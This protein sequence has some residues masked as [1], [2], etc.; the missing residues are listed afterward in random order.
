[1]CES[2]CC[3]SAAGIT[4]PSRSNEM[5]TKTTI[6]QALNL[7]R[8]DKRIQSRLEFCSQRKSHSGNRKR[9]HKSWGPVGSLGYMLSKNKYKTKTDKRYFVQ[10]SK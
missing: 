3:V 8:S 6:V 7:I 1:M 5:R 10:N 9:L 4:F 2:L